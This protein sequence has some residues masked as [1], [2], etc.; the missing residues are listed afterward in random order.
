MSNLVTILDDV[1]GTRKYKLLRDIRNGDYVQDK[2]G[3][4]NRVLELIPTGIKKV[5][6]VELSCGFIKPIC[7]DEDR[8]I[9]AIHIDK[10]SKSKKL[11]FFTIKEISLDFDR[12]IFPLG[13]STPSGSDFNVD[14]HCIYVKIKSINESPEDETYDIYVENINEYQLSSGIVFKSLTGNE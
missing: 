5:L 11:D 14:N 1:V 2:C 6:K 9:L 10:K 7:V 4:F 8:K 13:R 3:N 12:Y